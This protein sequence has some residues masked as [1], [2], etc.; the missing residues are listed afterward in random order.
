MASEA[1]NLATQAGLAYLTGGASLG[2]NVLGAGATSEPKMT[3]ANNRNEINVTP[4]VNIGAAIL[5]FTDS[6][7]NGGFGLNYTPTIGVRSSSRA[8]SA[9][10]SVQGNNLVWYGLAALAGLFV[11]TKLRRR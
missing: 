9:S 1:G 7:Y 11:L 2:G 5:P 4:Q 10:V 6:V 8:S 3:S